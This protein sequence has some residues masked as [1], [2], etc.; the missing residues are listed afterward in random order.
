MKYILR[1]EQQ[2]W[3]TTDADADGDDDDD[4]GDDDGDDGDDDD[5]DDCRLVD[6]SVSV[7]TFFLS[8]YSAVMD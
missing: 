1:Y 3:A 2:N 8:A 5:D 4:D 6:H 7:C